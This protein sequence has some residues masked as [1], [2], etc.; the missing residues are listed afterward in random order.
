MNEC[1][2]AL[3]TVR[4]RDSELIQVAILLV[5]QENFLAR[6]SPESQSTL[7]VIVLQLIHYAI[8]R[9]IQVIQIPNP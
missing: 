9:V 4:V 2:E 6:I 7:T 5:I 8:Q 1:G 3:V